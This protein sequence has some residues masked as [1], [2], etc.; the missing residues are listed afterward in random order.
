[1]IC[2][3]ICEPSEMIF[4]CNMIPELDEEEHT[5]RNSEQQRAGQNCVPAEE[6]VMVGEKQREQAARIA[7]LE[8]PRGQQEPPLAAFTRSQGGECGNDD[9]TPAF[10]FQNRVL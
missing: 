8:A 10:C 3:Y 7:R 9:A 6:R 5:S 4:Y 2:V 1:M